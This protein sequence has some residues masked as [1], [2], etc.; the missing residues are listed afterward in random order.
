MLN[1]DP[2]A[3]SAESVMADAALGRPSHKSTPIWVWATLV[4]GG[5]MAGWGM[6]LLG[7][8]AFVLA[9]KDL[10][11]GDPAR[12]LLGGIVIGVAPACF[13]AI[14]LIFGVKGWRSVRADP[15]D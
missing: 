10:G 11:D 5:L 7:I 13:G 14:L 6:L 8:I 4:L 15:D 9:T 12:L 1:L 2:T 3:N